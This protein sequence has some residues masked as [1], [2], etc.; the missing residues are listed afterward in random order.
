MSSSGLI[1]VLWLLRFWP[2]LGQLEGIMVKH[3]MDVKSIKSI[4]LMCLCLFSD[5]IPLVPKKGLEP[6]HPCEYVDLNHARLPIPPLRHGT[7]V[8]PYQTEQAATLSLANAVT[9][10]KSLKHLASHQTNPAFSLLCEAFP[11]PS[12]FDSSASLPSWLR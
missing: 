8:Q 4:V 7:H 11:P 12:S 3:V 1:C 9:C 2:D 10:V 5:R 6:P